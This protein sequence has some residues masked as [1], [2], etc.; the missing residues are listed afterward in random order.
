MRIGFRRSTQGQGV[1]L[2]EGQDREPPARL[3]SVGKQK[4][5]GNQYMR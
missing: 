5:P 3:E 2:K 1:P 4:I